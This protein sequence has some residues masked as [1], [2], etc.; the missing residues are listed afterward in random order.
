[1]LMLAHSCTPS[2]LGIAALNGQLREKAISRHGSQELDE[3][4]WLLSLD[5]DVDV[6]GKALYFNPQ[7]S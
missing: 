4:L 6:H 7:V 5:H 1:M 2:S 3:P